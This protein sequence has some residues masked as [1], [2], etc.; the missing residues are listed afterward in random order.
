MDLIEF[1]KRINS[2]KYYHN[3]VKI[4]GKGKIVINS[5]TLENKK[6]LK[7]GELKNTENWEIFEPWNYG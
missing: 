1:L 7:F 4:F 5:K 6:I 2:I 3:F